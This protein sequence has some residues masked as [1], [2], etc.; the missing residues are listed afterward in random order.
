MDSLNEADRLK[1]YHLQKKK[2]MQQFYFWITTIRI[3]VSSPNYIPANF[4]ITFFLTVEQCDIQKY[5]I[6]SSSTYQVRD[7][8]AALDFWR[9]RLELQW[10][11][12]NRYLRRKI[13]TLDRCSGMVELDLVVN[14]SSFLRNLHTD[15]NS[16]SISLCAFK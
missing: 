4:I 2:I 3:I 11:W 8:D 16:G 10:T 9:Q 12:I 6:F 15:L 1:G 13:R 7:I 14:H 5:F